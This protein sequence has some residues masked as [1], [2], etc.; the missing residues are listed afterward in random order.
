MLIFYSLWQ[1]A[2][3]K[4]GRKKPDILSISNATFSSPH[5]RSIFVSKN[6]VF[7]LINNCFP[8]MLLLLIYFHSSDS[9]DPTQ[10]EE[11]LDMIAGVQCHRMN[12]QRA[13]V[14]FLPGQFFNFNFI[15]S[16]IDYF[17]Y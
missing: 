1:H 13:A 10:K 14:P 11:L 5:D 12:E 9:I 8:I 2:N 4:F 15:N 6:I 3:K 7:I 16:I 17:D